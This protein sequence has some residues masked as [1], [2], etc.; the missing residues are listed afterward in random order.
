MSA[1]LSKTEDILG[2]GV[3]VCDL[4]DCVNQIV[5]GM[6][7]GTAQRWLACLNPH[8]YVTSL[9]DSVFEQAL[10]AADW[11]I[12]DGAGI[13]LASRMLGGQIRQRITGSDVFFALNDRMNNLGNHSVFFLGSSLENLSEIRQKMARDYPNIEVAGSYSPPYKSEYSDD[14]I[15][16]MLSAINTVK[17]DVLWVGMTAPKQ[18]KWLYQHLPQLDVK[19]AAA[20]GAVFDFYTGRVKRSHPVF[21]KTGLE[22]L[23]RLVQEPRRLWRRNFVSSPIFLRKVLAEK[24]RK[25]M[26]RAG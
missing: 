16:K 22:W 3:T 13:V 7:H 8:S 25:S 11:I 4:G 18:E 1:I 2:F 24:I 17:P 10:K 6:T 21:Q 20:I 12:P 26:P 15:S 19:F 9:E 14:D 5:A 23:P